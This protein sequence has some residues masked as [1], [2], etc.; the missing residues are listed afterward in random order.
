M[1]AMIVLL[2]KALNDILAHT[3]VSAAGGMALHV[4]VIMLYCMFM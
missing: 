4:H 1:E 2:M 3:T